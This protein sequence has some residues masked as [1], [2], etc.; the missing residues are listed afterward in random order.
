MTLML[1]PMVS[2]R[3]PCELPGA[4][5]VSIINLSTGRETTLVH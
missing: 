4:R 5:V 1:I 2:N 3:L